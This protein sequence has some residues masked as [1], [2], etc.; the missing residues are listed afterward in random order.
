MMVTREY[1]I[2]IGIQQAEAGAPSQ[3]DLV[4]PQWGRVHVLEYVLGYDRGRRC[5]LCVMNA[6]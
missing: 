1:A 6:W 2:L 5:T 3:Y 4:A